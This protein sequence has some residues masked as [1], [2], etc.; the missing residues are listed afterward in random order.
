MN[1]SRVDDGLVAAR[2]LPSGK[3]GDGVVAAVEMSPP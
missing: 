2:R 1:A 3:A